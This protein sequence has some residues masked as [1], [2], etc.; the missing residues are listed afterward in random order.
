MKTKTVRVE[1]EAAGNLALNLLTPLQGELKILKDEN[2]EKLKHEIVEDGFSF[3]FSVWESEDDGKIYIL[4]GHQRLETLKRMASEGYS[5]P[6][7]PVNFVE[8]K[9]IKQAMR[10]L[11]AAASNYGTMQKDGL[12]EFL[13]LAE[14]DHEELVMSFQFSDLNLESLFE[15]ISI[16]PVQTEEK[17]AD[18]S[19][20]P[21]VQSQVRM[22]QL[23]FNSETQPE[24]LQKTAKLQELGEYGNLTD[25]VMGVIREAF[26]R[27]KK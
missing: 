2:Y 26:D 19:P 3:A 8:A 15:D 27:L 9:D 11:L 4:D 24:F 22:V 21:S 7:V 14:I 20:L 18:I 13:E 5:V 6:A 17:I 10:K 16:D 25:T 12:L 1:V 23:F